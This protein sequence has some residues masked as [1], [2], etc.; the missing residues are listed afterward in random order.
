MLLTATCVAVHLP[1]AES[2]TPSVIP[3]PAKLIRQDGSFT[4]RPD[5]VIFA[6]DV[7]RPAA[8]Q[9]AAR[10]RQATGFGLK[11]RA[12]SVGGQARKGSLRLTTRGAKAALGS[13]GYELIVA[14]AVTISA[15]QAAGVFYGTQTLLQL[16]PPAA[17]GTNVAR[18]ARWTIPALRIEDQP[19]FG[20]RGMLLDV[21]RHYF[22]VADIKRVLDVMALHK[23]NTF[24]WHLTE[25]QGW[26]IEIKK[27]PRL[28]EVGAWR[29]S[30]PPYGNR[31]SDD[32]MRYG[33]FYT[34]AEVKDIVA[35]AA[36]RHITVVPEI[37]MPGHAAAAIAS[38]PE[39][40]NSDIPGYA[41][42][43]MTRWSVHPYT[44]AP[45]EETFRF[46]EDV[47]TEVCELFPSKFIHIGGDEAPKDQW[48]ESAFAQSVIKREGLKDEH[49]LQS[50]F[51]RR[52]ERFL[53]TQGRRL[54][55]WDEIQEGGLPKTATMMVWRDAKW[56]RHA[57]ALGNNVVM[58]TS[59]DTYFCWYQA[60][61]ETE[62]A[63]GKWFEAHGGFLPLE[64]VYAFNP[65]SVAETPA[66]E[67]L[68]LGTSVQIWTEFIKDFA[69][70]QY[71]AFPRLSAFAEVAWTP[72]AMRHFE[73]FQRR[74]ETHYQRYDQLGL[75]YYRPTPAREALPVKE[76]AETPRP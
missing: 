38:Y 64:K 71:M 8:E 35:Y 27:Y 18:D 36:A 46:L 73:D 12:D 53:A 57:L 4:L 75:R 60:P 13:E 3:Q 33:G 49:E 61:A 19:R 54:V 7:S 51:I 9:L 70:L 66:Q 28:T 76:E 22:P 56:A 69:K 32:G 52:I 17:L 24:H 47:L 59:S 30:T 31:D 20:W 5:A 62:L 41:P 74:L 34:Q 16:L 2:P 11:I 48:K 72:Q 43:V 37:E 6:D 21:G 67:E 63:K 40:G 23:L 44:F 26:R 68:I 29:A 1:A 15:P 55:G 14:D 39:F 50:W 42:R 65:T 25:D 45:K 58:A 10:L